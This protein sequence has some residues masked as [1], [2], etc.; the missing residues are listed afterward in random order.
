MPPSVTNWWRLEARSRDP[1]LAEALEARLADPVWS[2]GRQWQTG[3]FQ[4]VDAGTPVNA[5]V[6]LTVQSLGWYRSTAPDPD[7]A[8]QV[9]ELA[10]RPLDELVEAEPAP[11]DLRLALAGGRQW[12]RL[13]R[14]GP[15]V[16]RNWIKAGFAVTAPGA[17]DEPAPDPDAERLL[18]ATRDRA[19]DGGAIYDALVQATEAGDFSG[20]PGSTSGV[21]KAAPGY[22]AWWES[23]IGKQRGP[24]PAP[25]WNDRRMEYAFEVATST[26]D[27]TVLAAS[28][29]RGDG[30]DWPSFD[31]SPGTTVRAGPGPD[32]AS[33][34]AAVLPS[35][36]TFKGMPAPRWWQ[37]EDA[38]VSF[39]AID[40][41]PDDLARLVAIEFALVYGNDFFV[42][43]VRLPL[44]TL[45]QITSL[46][47][48]DSFGWST[49]VDSTETV[50][51]PGS[52]W[53]M[54][55]LAPADREMMAEPLAALL[56][57]AST[58]GE[59]DGDGIEDVLFVRDDAAA[60]AWAVESVVPGRGGR[61]LD[62]A[63][64][65]AERR[66]RQDLVA[67]E[68]P[69][70]PT[71][72]LRYRLATDVPEYWYPLL[73]RQTGLRA[74]DFEL[75]QASL[76]PNPTPDPLGAVLRSSSP[77]RIEEEELFGPA[78]RVRRRVRRVRWSDGSVHTWVARRVSAGRGASSSGL[79]FDAVVTD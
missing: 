35:P 41:A 65:A 8:A 60:M 3:E 6:R 57:P 47:V 69:P 72:A 36:V 43:P 1:R 56:L 33:V 5:R 53:H 45:S 20:L 34:V 73:P 27:E 39:P 11:T 74:I 24:A 75:A 2:L 25:A 9:L 55:K 61:P 22:V 42:L 59:I 7:A 30:L 68:P 18:G 23:R 71:G 66:R 62:R 50:D 63:M 14:A 76:G 54:F 79:R 26:G 28:Q 13:L 77:L 21:E 64:S 17:G 78:L 58:A 44:G 46:V 15:V 52:A 38:A 4:G 40:A 16:I 29:Y 31:H 48:E 67:A 32:P 12:V 37:F 49:L 10:N 19:L 51:G 70:A